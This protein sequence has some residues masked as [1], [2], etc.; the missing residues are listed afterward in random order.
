MVAGFFSPGW[1][2]HQEYPVPRILLLHSYHQG[3][4]WSDELTLGIRE[5]LDEHYQNVDLDIQYLDEKRVTGSQLWPQ[6]QQVLLQEILLEY[7]P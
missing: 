4:A 6:M 5:Q 7:Y 1:A 3:F 2:D